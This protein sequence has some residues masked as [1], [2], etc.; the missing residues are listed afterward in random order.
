M[1]IKANFPD[2]KQADKDLLKLTKWLRLHQSAFNSHQ[3]LKIINWAD[4]D[5]LTHFQLFHFQAA[6]DDSALDITY[7]IMI[8]QPTFIPP[9]KDANFIP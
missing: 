1:K 2:M 4:K 8:D 5:Y 6:K 7:N 3:I 9:L